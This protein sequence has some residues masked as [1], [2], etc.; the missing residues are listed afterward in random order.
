MAKTVKVRVAGQRWE[1]R[2]RKYF[3]DHTDHLVHDPNC[4]LVIGDTVSLHRLRVSKAVHHVVGEL[5]TPYSVPREERPPIPTPD[6][7]LAE[8]KK[9]RFQKLYRRSLRNSAAEGNEDAEQKLKDLGLDTAPVAEADKNGKTR[10][11]AGAGKTTIDGKG[12]SLSRKGQNLPNV[13]V[14]GGTPD[15]RAKRDKARVIKLN[16][17]AAENLAEASQKEEQA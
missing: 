12:M 10:L 6:E 3:A 2:I 16:K 7:R 17:Q 11:Q 5:M 8:Y 14:P 13:A 9:H 4:S 1:P 15:E